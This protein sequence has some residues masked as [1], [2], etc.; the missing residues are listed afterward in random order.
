MTF[1]FSFDKDSVSDSNVF[2]KKIQQ[3]VHEK[4]LAQ[5]QVYNQLRQ[6]GIE[7]P[8]IILSVMDTGLRIGDNSSMFHFDLEVH[9][10][11]KPPFRSET[12]STVSDSMRPKFLP[13]IHVYVKYNPDDQ[14]Q[15]ALD[16][17]AFDVPRAKV[18]TCPY[19]SAKQTLQPGQTACSYC[20]K[21][22]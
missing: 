6:I 8:A 5:E 7:A 3:Q 13:G 20:G 15:V 19:C 11:N 18:M 4:L 21:P 16:R 14:T 2:L 17:A 12:H 22:I 1:D 9:P 10:E